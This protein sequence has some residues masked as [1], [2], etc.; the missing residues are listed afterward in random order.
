MPNYLRFTVYHH[1]T[2]ENPEFCAIMYN[3]KDERSRRCFRTIGVFMV[4]LALLFSLGCQPEGQTQGEEMREESPPIPVVVTPVIRGEITSYVEASGTIFPAR[5]SKIGSKISGKIEKI[6]ADEGDMVQKGQPLVKLDQTDLIIT[7]KQA[8]GNLRTA[9][10]RAEQAR[11]NLEKIKKDWIRLSRLHQ[12]GVISQQQYDDINMNYRIAQTQLKL[13]NGEVQQA[14]ITLDMAKQQ[15]LNSVTLS[16]FSGLVVKKFVNE[17]EIISIMPPV[18]LFWIMDIEYVKVEVEVPEI[19]ITTIKVG[20]RAR[21]RGDGF[22]NRIFEGRVSVINPLVDP[23]SRTFRVKIDIANPQH[24]L[25]AGMFA[26]VQIV[27]DEHN[28]VLF[29]P[30]DALLTRDGKQVVFVAENAYAIMRPIEVGLTNDL[31]V[32]ITNGV[33]EGEM[34]VVKGGYGLE[35]GVKII[36]AAGDE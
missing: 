36:R 34:V 23:T 12:K 20:Q 2:S 3:M 25:K 28:G 33:N 8:E 11:L 7:Q 27:V 10:A 4:L 18:P 32:E 5:E 14:R 26:R 21:I 1:H 29:V 35:D 6:Y 31:H 9:E 22:P 13:V 19:E 15:L 24:I 30:R 17:G 16:P